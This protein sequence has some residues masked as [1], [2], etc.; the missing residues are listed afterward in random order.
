MT[1]M[2][3]YLVVKVTPCPCGGAPAQTIRNESGEAICTVATLCPDCDGT[4]VRREEVPLEEALRELGLVGD[5]AIVEEEHPVESAV[6][7]AAW[8]WGWGCIE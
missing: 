2:T 3:Q 5:T 6:D 8:G 7:L 4:G 1:A